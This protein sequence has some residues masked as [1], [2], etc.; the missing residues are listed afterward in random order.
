MLKA[1]SLIPRSFKYW[2]S[3]IGLIEDV[4]FVQKIC[5]KNMFEK[6][7]KRKNVENG[8]CLI[9]KVDKNAICPINVMS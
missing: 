1:P 5:S 3:K 9:K 2:Y 8:I 4:K 7:L 6:V